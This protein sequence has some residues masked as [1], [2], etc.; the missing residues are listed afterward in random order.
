MISGLL[1]INRSHL[2][3]NGIE[4]VFFFSYNSQVLPIYV[5]HFSTRLTVE[6][7]MTFSFLQIRRP[8]CEDPRYR[9][10]TCNCLFI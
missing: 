7:I 6:F 2:L 1:L 10:D 8:P 9:L 3:D 5:L 4:I